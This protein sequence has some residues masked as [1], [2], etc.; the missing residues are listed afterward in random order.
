MLLRPKRTSPLI[1]C[2]HSCRC[3]PRCTRTN[4]RSCTCPW[5]K[6]A[7]VGDIQKSGL[8][9]SGERSCMIWKIPVKNVRYVNHSGGASKRPVARLLSLR[10]NHHRPLPYAAG[11]EKSLYSPA[12]A[13][14][15]GARRDHA[16]L[17]R[18][19]H[20]PARAGVT[21]R[22]RRAFRTRYMRGEGGE[23]Y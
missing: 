3:L 11:D 2:S 21:A 5:A 7:G 4:R 8:M 15:R 19:L 17:R 9:G 20:G 14:V 10:V 13:A 1:F 12:R 22:A 23:K 18:L 16:R 6:M